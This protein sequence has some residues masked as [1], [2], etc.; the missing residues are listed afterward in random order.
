MRPARALETHQ[1]SH[2]QESRHEPERSSHQPSC[3]RPRRAARAVRPRRVAPRAGDR[4]DL[5][6][7]G[8]LRRPLLPVHPQRRLEPRRRHRQV[9]QLLDR[10]G[11]R[12]A[13]RVRRQDRVRLFRRDQRGGARVRRPR[14]PHHRARPAAAARP[15]SPA[16][17]RWPTAPR[18][19]RSRPQPLSDDR[20]DRVARRGRQGRPAA[21]DREV[22]AGKGSA[23]HPG[24]GRARGRARHR[25]GDA[26]G[27][28]AWR[29]TCGR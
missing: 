2:L 13:R 21:Q 18:I 3:R 15:G 28:R 16:R 11:R 5:R 1:R 6:A 27:R 19:E 23:H 7:Q 10:A 29:P 22:R 25:H 4:H 8:R 17:R 14:H 9:R 26:L 24:D 20:P 12:R